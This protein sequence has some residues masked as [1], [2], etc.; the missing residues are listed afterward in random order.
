ML[1]LA[2][3]RRW[4]VTAR[5]LLARARERIDALNVFPVPDGDTGTN[6]FLTVDGSLDFLRGQHEVTGAPLRLDQGLALLARGMLLSARG[7][8]GVILSQLARGLSEAV[9]QDGGGVDEVGPA[10]LADAFERAADLAWAGV[11]RPVEGTILSVATAAATGARDAVVPTATT[12]DVALAALDAARAALAQTT[13]QL[14]RLAAAGVVDAGG[15]GLVL[16]IEALE[17]VLSGR[18]HEGMP[19]LAQWWEQHAPSDL[20]VDGD[21]AALDR[22]CE[23]SDGT[24][25]VM[26]LLEG[27]DPERAH[28]LRAHLV[29]IGSSVLVVGGP[30]QWRIHVHLDDPAPAVEAGSLA[31]RVEQVAITRLIPAEGGDGSERGDGSAGGGGV[32]DPPDA[33]GA[34]AGR[35]SGSRS[36]RDRPVAALGVVAC[37]PGAGLAAVLARAGAE[38]VH[39][40]AGRR[41]STGQLLGAVRA[42]PAGQVLVLPNDPDTILAAEAAARAA[43]DEGRSVRVLPT[44]AAVQGLA[45]MAVCDLAGEVESTLVTMADAAAAVAYGALTVADD[46]GTTPAGPCRA[47]QWLGLVGGEIIGVHDRRKDAAKQVLKALTKGVS[48]PP[49]LLTVVAGR[50]TGP[51]DLDKPLAR[52]ARRHDDVEVH[53]LDGGQPTYRW[54]LGLE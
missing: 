47:G 30:T 21:R 20:A 44:R 31:G 1:D 52:W 8:S 27:S 16:V 41:A 14:P 29:R 38:V 7:N 19:G 26:Y 15:A 9:A 24:H 33:A 18:P 25:E 51:A 6:L 23:S 49:E 48:G 11:S 34:V 32:A 46:D 2:T 5:A 53:R 12:Y 39:S 40:S 17:N 28:H 10:A 43:A 4:A 45:A 50:G 36:R 37:A 42:V 35:A 22:T 3:A 54:L 13:E